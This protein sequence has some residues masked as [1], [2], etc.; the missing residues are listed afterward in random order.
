MTTAE[1]IEGMTDAGK[2]EILVTRV[3]RYVDDDC[4]LLEHMGVNAAGKTI[5]NLIDS[6]CMVPGTNPPRFVMAMFTTDKVQSLKHKWLFDHES[7]PNA[8]RATS[9]DDGDLIKAAG[10]LRHY[11]GIISMQ[12]SW[13]ICAPTSSLTTT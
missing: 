11:A 9:A 5:P 1:A 2:F 3:L 8:K 12:R 10:E 13:S 4:R 7:A 6:F